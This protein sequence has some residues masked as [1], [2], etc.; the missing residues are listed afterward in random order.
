MK[1]L[2]DITV[3]KLTERMNSDPKFRE[4]VLLYLVMIDHLGP[5]NMPLPVAQPFFE[6]KEEAM[7]DFERINNMRIV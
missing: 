4:S 3:E 6:C 7:K 1:K 5:L 2:T